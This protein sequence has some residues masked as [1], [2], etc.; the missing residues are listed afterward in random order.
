MSRR[1]FITGHFDVQ[2][3]IAPRTIVSVSYV[4][5]R[6]INISA[7]PTD[8][9]GAI[10]QNLNQVDPKLSFAWYGIAAAR[11]QSLRGHRHHGI[12]GW[13]DCCAVAILFT[14]TL[15]GSSPA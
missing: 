15:P 9:T 4:G 1:S 7:A 5:S 8:F 6:A 2:R 10:N 11:Y 12:A 3:E 13:G 14:E